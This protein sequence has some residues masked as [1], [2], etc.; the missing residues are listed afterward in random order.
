M[1]IKRDEGFINFL[2]M[3]LKEAQEQYAKW[4]EMESDLLAEQ[5]HIRQLLYDAG[6]REE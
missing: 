6:W 1:A 4:E 3:Q 2:L 5:N